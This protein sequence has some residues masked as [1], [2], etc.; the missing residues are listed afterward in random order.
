MDENGV[1]EI[2]IDNKISNIERIM[3]NIFAC[4]GLRFKEQKRSVDY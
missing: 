3:T 2:K 4:Q 1:N